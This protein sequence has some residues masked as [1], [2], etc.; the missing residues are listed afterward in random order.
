MCPF[1]TVKRRPERDHRSSGGYAS[2]WAG[3]RKTRRDRFRHP[4]QCEGIANQAVDRAGVRE[5]STRTVGQQVRG[6]WDADALGASG[7]ASHQGRHRP[8]GGIRGRASADL[9]RRGHAHR[10]RF[11]R[12]DPAGP[13]GW[14]QQQPH[15]A[16]WTEGLPGPLDGQSPKS[17]KV[18]DAQRCAAPVAVRIWGTEQGPRSDGAAG[19]PIET[20]HRGGPWQGRRRDGP[21]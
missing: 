8:G 15:A 3:V 5:P 4:D 14:R 2:N 7:V 12:I 16:A 11:R 20:R 1:G 6:V 21:T 18:P 13:D 17:M 10:E 9:G 19:L